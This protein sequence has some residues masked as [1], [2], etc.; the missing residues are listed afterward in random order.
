[1]TI[2]VAPAR[3]ELTANAGQTIFN[4]TFKIFSITDL[5]VYITPAGQ[6]ANDST[7]LTTAYTVLG[8]G[9]EDGGTITLT[10]GANLNDLVTIVSNVPSSRTTDY[11]NNGDF[12]PDTVN[13]DFDRVVSI[14]KKIEDSTNRSILLPQ[15]Q[16]GPKPL[17][18]PG[19]QAGKLLRWLGDLSGL[20]NIDVSELSPGLTTNDRVIFS[21]ASL[22][23]AV[24]ST[25]SDII[26]NL[27]PLNMAGRQTA[28]DKGEAS[29]DVVLTISVI[30]NGFDI[31]QSVGIP[32]L[33]FVLRLKPV[34][35][36]VEFGIVSDFIESPVSGTPNDG[37]F[38]RMMIQGDTVSI[39]FSIPEGSYLFNTMGTIRHNVDVD[40]NGSVVALD[41]TGSNNDS[42]FQM[43]DNTSLKNIDRILYRSTSVSAFS[44]LGHI[45]IG[46]F[47]AETNGVPSA[48]DN[49]LD[50]SYHEVE[51]VHIE[52][53]KGFYSFQALNTD[54]PTGSIVFIVGGTDVSTK[55]IFANG[56]AGDGIRVPSQS[57]VRT[58][59]G[60]D[61]NVRRQ[62]FNIII[63]NTTGEF[64][65]AH[66][67]NAVVYINGDRSTLAI[68]TIGTS[69]GQIYACNTNGDS[70][71]Q[72]ASLLGKNGINI[73]AIGVTGFL[74]GRETGDTFTKLIAG[75]NLKA[76]APEDQ[77]ENNFVVEVEGV[78]LGGVSAVADKLD[79]GIAMGDVSATG[80]ID[81]HRMTV[82]S[83][84]VHDHDKGV[85]IDST[86]TGVLLE[87]G[88]SH[89]NQTNGLEYKGKSNMVRLVKVDN[90]NRA[91]LSDGNSFNGHGVNYQA[92]NS[93]MDTCILGDE[94]LATGSETQ[95]SAIQ[96]TGN[97]A[98]LHLR[99]CRFENFK[100][101]FNDINL[102]GGITGTEVNI[103]SECRG[104]RNIS[105]P[106]YP[107]A[108]GATIAELNATGLGAAL[109][110]SNCTVSKTST[111]RYNVTFVRQPADANYA[112]NATAVGGT[113][114]DVNM[115]YSSASTASFD[116]Y[117]KVGGVETDAAFSVTVHGNNGSIF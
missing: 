38:T 99:N 102:R 56:K 103:D 21:F 42:V 6:D 96:V 3:N 68:N 27:A 16:Q 91:G 84:N 54:R 37:A 71:N 9:D 89:H 115:D 114:A 88:R 15:S 94:D 95:L 101:G 82:K 20:E 107:I 40:F 61:T 64:L 86:C 105:A 65:R 33:S 28:N 77:T 59:T 32:T 10:T 85:L 24:A 90:N 66:P 47:Y 73:K 92:K 93:V 35:T 63:E 53:V 31:V 12:R 2:T 45:K 4:Y 57:V 75:V 29:W 81:N 76:V 7:D 30:P 117:T 55:N 19:P 97:D 106:V 110:S 60:F 109:Y 104:V 51:N 52:N 50:S 41:H 98:Q 1:M 69:C 74:C 17:S 87:S 108:P 116:V 83:F 22:T 14:V 79:F 26:K 44:T 8:V 58:E 72:S 13:A 62:G 46:E 67:E 48:G 70:T 80:A 11:Q 39:D 36:G 112:I 78:Y 5:N 100:T 111:G 25:D 34:M 18:L 43:G 49:S 23:E 113:G